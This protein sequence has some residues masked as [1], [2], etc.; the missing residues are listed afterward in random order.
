[1]DIENLKTKIF[2]KLP[3]SKNLILIILGAIGVLIILLSS[4][5]KKSNNKTKTETLK[6]EDSY[7]EML[8][9]KLENMVS[10]MLG[11]SVVSVLVTLESGTEYIYA[12]E[13]KTDVGVKEIGSESKKEQN[14]SN[15]KTYVIVKDADGSENAL[16]VQTK[17]PVIRGVVIVCE[18][19]QTASVSVAVKAAVKSA[20]NIDAEKIC[21][22]GRY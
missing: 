1:M 7:V 12:S 5:S 10:D 2:E 19:G 8:E 21:I 15:Q 11:G 9:S 18:D 22:I 6:N 4:Q 13:Y 3:K 17:M 14:D 16:I 20:L